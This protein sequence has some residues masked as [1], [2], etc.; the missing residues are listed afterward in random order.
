MKTHT[1]L[2]KLTIES[3]ESRLGKHV[4][5]LQV[6][7]EIAYSHQAAMQIIEEGRG[8]HFD[9]DVV[10]AFIAVQLACKSIADQYANT[11][12]ELAKRP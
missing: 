10:D 1:T 11:D 7:K 8:R 3:A 5:F 9:P 2:G 12:D 4:P 6:A